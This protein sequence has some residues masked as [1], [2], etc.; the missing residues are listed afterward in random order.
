[1]VV[2]RYNLNPICISTQ[3]RITKY[4]RPLEQLLPPH[5]NE[6][7]FQLLQPFDFACPTNY[8]GLQTLDA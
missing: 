3:T 7:V 5:E 8:A 2:H 6:T 1:M 4:G